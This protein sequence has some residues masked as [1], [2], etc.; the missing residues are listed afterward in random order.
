[1]R[2]ILAITHNDLRVYFS[3]IGN[4]I[5][6]IALPVGLTLV[7]GFALGGGGGADAIYA[8]VIDEDNSVAS[9]QFVTALQDAN[10][11]L[12]LCGIDEETNNACGLQGERLTIE[13]SIE[14]VQETDLRALIV[15]PQDYGERMRQSEPVQI[16]Y[17]ATASGAD[18]FNDP[19]LTAVQTAIQQANAVI[20]V[21]A[22]A[23]YAIENYQ[24]PGR[25]VS[26]YNDEEARAQFRSA[27]RERADTLLAQDPARV[28][29]ETSQDGDE[30]TA[31]FGTGFGQAVP[32]QGATFVMF[33]VLG[34]MALLVRERKQW[35]LQRL[36]VSPLSRA[37][38][39]SG[40]I[41]AYV[42]LGMIQFVII[43]FV[44]L[45][46]G[47]DFGNAPLAIFALM[48]SFVLATTALGF[49]L[50]TLLDNENQV[51]SVS[52][53]L[54]LTLAPLGGAWWPLAITPDFMQVIGHI[55]PVA[56]AM[57]GFNEIIF[58]GGGFVDILLPVGV[59]LGITVVFFGL[60]IVT[61]KYE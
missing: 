22:A 45:L 2:Q 27:V 16:E 23:G 1:M 11:T 35:T 32:G 44:G 19:V 9:Q 38:I 36:L 7:L 6:L 3:D 5:G 48:V 59:L 34:G 25:T 4:L 13:R 58:F 31:D 21:S 41:L 49:A 24:L 50:S 53:L 54:A 42:T 18:S 55:S 52:L 30:T 33:T 40:K 47:T 60:G 61:F 37:Q 51:G 14:R 26:L 56:W 43:F 15:I 12:V 46:T 8:D 28:Q 17:Y 29:Y 39:L 10:Q 20:T 57:D